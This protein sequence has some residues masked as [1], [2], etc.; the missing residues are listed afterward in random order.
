MFSMLLEVIQHLFV[1]K[2]RPL[3]TFDKDIVDVLVDEMAK[4][5]PTL[6]THANVTEV[7]KNDDSLTISLIMEKRLLLI[8]SSGLL[9]AQLTPLVLDLK[10][11]VLN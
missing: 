10:R 6:H 11:Q 1:R 2:D 3:R 9:D 8:A 5:G 4:S 7:V